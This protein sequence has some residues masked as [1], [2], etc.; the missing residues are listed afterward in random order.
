VSATS[1]GSQK[2]VEWFFFQLVGLFSMFPNLLHRD[3]MSKYNDKEM[4]VAAKFAELIV[5]SGRNNHDL[6]VRNRVEHLT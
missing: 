6:Y 2:L 5:S 1:S 4:S 3:S